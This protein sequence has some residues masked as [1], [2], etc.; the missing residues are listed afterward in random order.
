MCGYATIVVYWITLILV[1]H[2]SIRYFRVSAILVSAIL[3]LVRF[4]FNLIC[5]AFLWFLYIN[6][7]TVYIVSMSS[8]VTRVVVLSSWVNGAAVTI[9]FVSLL[10]FLVV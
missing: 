9:M 10:S 4:Y 5:I 6:T 3:A 1:L 8:L 2:I 7:I